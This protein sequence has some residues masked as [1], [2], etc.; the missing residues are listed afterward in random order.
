MAFN[1]RRQYENFV[2]ELCVSPDGG[3]KL[4][5]RY[6]L[7]FAPAAE[8]PWWRLGSQW[9]GRCAA[10]GK[11][12][13]QPD[14]DGLTAECFAALTADPRRYG[15]HA[16]LKAPFRLADG[17]RVEEIMDELDDITSRQCSFALPPL[18]VTRLDDFLA[19]TPARPSQHIDRMAQ[20]CVTHFDRFRAPLTVCERAKRSLAP[21]TLRERMFLEQWGYPYVLDRFR[22]HF[23][24]S[25][26]L[27]EVSEE[28]RARLARA[29]VQTFTAPLLAPLIFDAICIFEEPLPGAAF[30][31]IHRSRFAHQGRL[32]YVVGPSGAGK[33]SV[34]N[35][36]REH[37]VSAT[38]AVFTQ[39]TIT[40]P[41]HMDGE[42]HHALTEAQFESL[43]QSGEFAMCWRAHG[44][45]YAI[46]KQI[47]HALHRGFTVVVSGSRDH[48]PQALRD[49]PSLEVVHINASPEILRQRLLRRG[50]EA[51]EDVERRLKREALKVPDGMRIAEIR[52]DGDLAVAGASFLEYLSG[53]DHG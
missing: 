32:V 10:S 21:L 51:A 26:S 28:V 44:H 22:F 2:T 40:R 30:R 33:D 53:G 24:L 5:A 47:H 3:S 46:S 31:L 45:S 43:R 49:F 20:R 15:F 36:A 9:L 29:A 38:Q 4:M 25:G 41:V 35:W 42:S 50:R 18:K 7:Y 14:I 16:T 8:N 11:S 6:A 48:L 13:R 23:S 1:L 34:I 19:L 39:R 37:L 12:L 27:A 17:L 52:N